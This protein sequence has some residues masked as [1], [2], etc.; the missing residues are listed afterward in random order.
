MSRRLDVD[1]EAAAEVDAQVQYYADRA[2]RHVALRFV[3]EIESIYH[4]LIERRL[5]GVNHSRVRFRLPVKRVFL[6]RFPFAIVFYVEDETIHVVSLEALRR[7][8]G[9]WRARLRG[10]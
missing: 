4:G 8:P 5:V 9:Y 10:R 2:G 1:E 7:Q 3:A 6:D